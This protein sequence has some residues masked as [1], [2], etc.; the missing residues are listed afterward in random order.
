MDELMDESSETKVYSEIAPEFDVTKVYEEAM[1]NYATAKSA[2]EEIHNQSVLDKS[3]ALLGKQWEHDILSQRSRDRKTSKVFDNCAKY[4]RYVANSSLK[5][6]PAIRVSPKSKDKKKEAEVIA[7]IVRQIEN[8]SNAKQVY[9][10]AFTDCLAGGIGVFE[11]IVDL[12]DEENKIKIKKIIDPTS[13]YFDPSANEPDFSDAQYV[14]RLKKINKKKFQSLYPD[15]NSDCVSEKNRDWFND[16]NI[17]ILEYWTKNG[18]IVDWYLLNGNEILDSSI[19][20]GG[21]QGTLLPFVFMIGE[22]V[23]VNGERHIKSI[24]R[25][26][27]DRQRYFNFVNSESID[28]L[29]RASQGGWLLTQKTAERFL[30]IYQDTSKNNN[31]LV[32]PAGTDKPVRID[33]PQAPTAYLQEM[34]RLENEMRSTVGVRDPFSDDVPKM[35]SGKAVKLELGQQNLSTALWNDRLSCAIKY[36]G[37]VLVDL[38]PKFQN[39]AHTQQI[40]GIDGQ[41]SSEDIMTPNEKGEMIDLNA[42]YSVNVSTGAS[43]QD[44]QEA[45]F[46]K[47][48]ELYKANPQMFAVGSDLLVRNLDIIES[49]TLADRL[50]AIMPPQIKSMSKGDQDPKMV[51]MQ[52]KNQMEEMGKV[53]EQTTQALNQKTQESNQLQEMNQNKTQSEM[54]KLESQNQNKLQ[55][56]VMSN[57]SAEQQIVMKGEY[58]LKMKEMEMQYNLRM[59]E[60]E[61]E[62]ERVKSTQTFIQPIL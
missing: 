12:D 20:H 26:I 38:I 55:T 49:D 44:Q 10:H 23:I 14:M 3:F 50:F 13:V 22:D 17:D 27:K 15:K 2:W 43:Y 7:G 40:I 24:I 18:N 28:Y 36:C 61:L 41:Q 54:M 1:E 52:M 19:Y 60:L 11:V 9:N 53:L 16:D 21:Y 51:M 39:Y 5:N 58:D 34:S 57:Q 37:K 62:I 46:D 6:S 8:D 31:V 33:P 45:T 30:D 4:I 56:E 47:L 42:S 29:S 32:Y 25:D 35:Q 59:K 48:L